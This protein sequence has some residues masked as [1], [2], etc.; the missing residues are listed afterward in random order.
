MSRAV[1]DFGQGRAALERRRPDGHRVANRRGG[2]RAGAAE[3]RVPR[4]LDR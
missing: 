2:H 4:A 3:A 1:P